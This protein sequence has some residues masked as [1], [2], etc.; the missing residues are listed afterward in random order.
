[1]APK[2]RNPTIDKTFRRNHIKFMKSLAGYDAPIISIQDGKKV[3]Y[4]Y[5]NQD[6]SILKKP[7]ST[8]EIE[9]LNEALQTLNRMKNLHGFD[10]VDSISAKINSGLELQ[11]SARKIISFEEN[12][13]LVGSEF[14]SP[15]YQFILNKNAI[16]I[17]YKSFKSEKTINI[18]FSPQFLKQYNNRW[19]VFGINSDYG[20]IQ[21]LA[22][23][24]I[25]KI[26]VSK[27]NYLDT[28]VDYDEYFDDII[29][30]SNDLEK[31]PIKVILQLT[32]QVA[33]YIS[34]KPLHGSQKIK[35][36]L[37]TLQV[38]HNQELETL[39]LSFGERIKV[40]EPE[41]L[42]ESLKL[43]ISK[44]YQQYLD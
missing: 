37:L 9:N 25:K 36:K 34:T 33:P 15:L 5:E 22:L 30:V 14:L 7:L 41:S 31:E 4:Q 16:K 43:R 39:L 6:F 1:M 40:L 32:D 27:V 26:S 12:E 10:W 13:F 19:F 44:Q 35:G 28:A 17:S 18:I 2:L 21:N 29:G 11:N 42:L 23:D 8:K 24:R 38:K 3:Y 20:N